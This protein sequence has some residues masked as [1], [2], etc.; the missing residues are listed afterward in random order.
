MLIFF[1]RCLFYYGISSEVYTLSLPEK[2]LQEAWP[3]V[4]GALK[5]FG[6]NAELNLVSV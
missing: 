6:I 5:E 4:R 3:V 1:I 2:Y